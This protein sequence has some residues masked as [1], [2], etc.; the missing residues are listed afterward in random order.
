MSV[1][2]CAETPNPVNRRADCRIAA[3]TVLREISFGIAATARLLNELDD[4]PGDGG[5][6]SAT[7]QP[8]PKQSAALRLAALD[9]P[10][11]PAEAPR[12]LLVRAALQVAEHDRRTIFL[13]QP[14]HLFVDR[15]VAIGVALCPDLDGAASH[16]SPRN[17]ARA[18][19][20]GWRWPGGNDAVR[21]A[22]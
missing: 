15:G 5:P 3:S 13:R 18:C 12:R 11:R 22:T 10:D 16:P 14:V 4:G 7:H 19:A 21:Q 9:G 2:T 17:A 20:A 6:Q 8:V 1:R